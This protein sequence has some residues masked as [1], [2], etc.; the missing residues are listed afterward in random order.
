MGFAKGSTHPTAACKIPEVEIIIGGCGP[1]PATAPHQPSPMRALSYYRTHH[2][3]G[4]G[5]LA[6]HTFINNCDMDSR[7]NL[8]DSHRIS[9]HMP[10]GSATSL[11]EAR[12]TV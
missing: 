9:W 4:L 12:R 3:I 10:H 8:T 2:G 5:L 1:P 11:R 7:L 6:R